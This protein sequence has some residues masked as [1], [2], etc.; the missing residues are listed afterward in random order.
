MTVRAIDRRGQEDTRLLTFSGIGEQAVRLT[1]PQPLDISR[2]ANAE[3]SLQVEYRVQTGPTG[4]VAVGMEG[5]S[6]PVTQTLRAAP[7]NQWQTLT[8]PL[9]C[10]ARAGADMAKIGTP[11]VLKT[12]GKLTIAVSDVRLASAQVP[13]DRCSL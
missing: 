2:E 12:S 11:L 9:R 5:V 10:L 4:P 6:V 1:S 13:Q 3:L 8:V 7:K